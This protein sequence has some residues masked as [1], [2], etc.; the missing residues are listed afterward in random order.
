MA[1]IN[2][3]YPDG[4]VFFS[5]ELNSRLYR[6]FHK[7]MHIVARFCKTNNISLRRVDV[8]DERGE[9]ELIYYFSDDLGGYNI[10]GLEKSI[11]D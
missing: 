7:D 11:R 2:L 9:N 3:I 8:T 5:D 1:F 6:Q 10:C 4:D